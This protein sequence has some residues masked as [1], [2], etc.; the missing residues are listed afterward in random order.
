MY[1]I[2]AYA[3]PE[4]SHKNIH[5][6]LADRAKIHYC[7]GRERLLAELK[8]HEYDL[9]FLFFEDSKAGM[10]LLDKVFQHIP[11]TPIILISREE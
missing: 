8:G 7:S 10:P 5:T 2:L 4:E 11:H 3:I 1:T 6:A 9:A